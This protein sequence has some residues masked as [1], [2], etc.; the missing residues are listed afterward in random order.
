MVSTQIKQS[1][2]LLFSEPLYT[3]TGVWCELSEV[4]EPKEW[5]L[6]CRYIGTLSPKEFR[7]VRKKVYSNPDSII[8]RFKRLFVFEQWETA[9][10]PLV[11]LDPA[12]MRQE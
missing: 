3:E 8:S 9:G 12:G 7:G 6:L 10:L 5:A 2:G 4:L 1:Q 11:C